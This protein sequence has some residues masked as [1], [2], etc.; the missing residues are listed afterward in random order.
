M[1]SVASLRRHPIN[2]GRAWLQ[3]NRQALI[4]HIPLAHRRKA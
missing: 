4:V 2:L 3:K 1:H